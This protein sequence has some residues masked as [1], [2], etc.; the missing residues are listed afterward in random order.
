MTMRM[1]R[2]AACA[3]AALSVLGVWSAWAGAQIDAS[4]Y[5][6]EAQTITL[7]LSG[8][9]ED[10]DLIAVQSMTDLGADPSQW[11]FPVKAADV[12]PGDTQAT[13]ALTGRLAHGGVV[14]FFLVKSSDYIPVEYLR[15][16]GNVW[17]DTG[18]VPDATTTI[19]LKLRQSGNN[20]P[21]FGIESKWFAFCNGYKTTQNIRTYYSFMGK[22]GNVDP[23][24]DGGVHEFSFGADGLVIDGANKTGALTAGA[25]TI[26][27]TLPLFGRRVDGATTPNKF[28][29]DGDI[30]WCRLMK[31]GVTERDYVAA[32]DGDGAFALYDK[33]NHAFCYKKGSG[34]LS[35]GN[36]AYG[37]DAVISTLAV[38]IPARLKGVAYAA[39]TGLVTLQLASVAENLQVYAARAS[40]DR[41]K[42]ADAWQDAEALR[43][44]DVPAGSETVSARLP[45][46]WRTK[47]C[48]VRFFLASALPHVPV[49]YLRTAG[50][51]W[52]DTGV[53]PDVTTTISL[54]LRQAGNNFPLFGIESKWFAFCNG[55]KTTQNIRTYYTFMGKEGD[56]DP[57]NDG[58]VHELSFGA[59]GLVIDGAN[60]TGALTAGTATISST[61]PLFGR[62]VDGATAPSRINDNGDIY[63]CRLVKGGETVRDYVA[64][65]VNGVP[66]FF[67]RRNG[68]YLYNS[69][70]ADLT[71]GPVTLD[72]L[73]VQFVSDAIEI[74]PESRVPVSAAYDPTTRK[75]TLAVPA[76]SQVKALYLAW[77]ANDLGDSV[78]AGW[79]VLRHLVNLAP[80]ETAFEYTLPAELGQQVGACRFFCGPVEIPE[81]LRLHSLHAS[82]VSAKPYTKPY[83]ETGLVPN[84]TSEIAMDCTLDQ[85]GTSVV[86]N[87]PGFGVAGAFYLFCNGPGTYWGFGNVAD[88]L[89][90]KPYAKHLR[91]WDRLS[92]LGAF[93]DNLR[94]V[95]GPFDA[96]TFAASTLTVKFFGRIQDAAGEI[97]GNANM[98]LYSVRYAQD[99][100]TYDYVPAVDADGKPG[101][102][103]RQGGGW[104]FNVGGG[105][106]DADAN[107]VGGEEVTD[108]MV[109]GVSA[110]VNI[111]PALSH[112]LVDRREV[113]V[114]VGAIG[115]DGYL[116]L[117]KGR[118]DCGDLPSAWDEVIFLGEVSAAGGTASYA[119]PATFIRS[120]TVTKVFYS[121]QEQPFG[122]AYS[123]IR[124]TGSQFVDTGI[125]ADTNTEIAVRCKIPE[126]G[127]NNY[128]PFGVSERFYCFDNGPST[129]WGF[130]GAEGN[131]A[132]YNDGGWHTITFGPNGI[133]IDDVE[134]VSASEIV[135]RQTDFGRTIPLFGRMDR[136]TGKMQWL[137]NDM[138]LS[139]ATISQGGAVVRDFMPSVKDGVAGLYDLVT[140]GFFPNDHPDKAAFEL[141]E[142]LG[143]VLIDSETFGAD[144]SVTAPDMGMIFIVR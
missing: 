100:R 62:R 134:K 72:G 144:A 49:A 108:A 129:Y 14:R 95:A 133:F 37:T 79:P 11:A 132:G 56:V 87:L 64:C 67:D 107:L 136:A 143:K 116:F 24:N 58:G 76:G 26:S 57:Y 88:G 32:V 13:V 113:R 74:I 52:M 93:V 5:D 139:H 17:M 35:A 119:L 115:S 30:Y 65:T 106:F 123:F 31:G 90:S 12:A 23:Y 34:D 46:A 127:S 91:H 68:T 97:R 28:N 96:A 102:Y 9:E 75:V 40:E 125:V 59:E 3:V 112:E 82:G 47:A 10:L 140:G 38:R 54:K 2:A 81:G 103:D 42:T 78:E 25:A 4:S 99:G 53:V 118:T 71:A 48:Q 83:L 101:V 55:Y 51:A 110:R 66:A 89:A 21:L 33:Q 15:T 94:P 130:W 85:T 124:S 6:A 61:L 121:R 111:G 141:G 131:F 50:S 22:E 135:T 120:G 109:D 29:T 122:E 60:K 36:L 137:Q 19:S 126:S 142:P 63:W 44:V 92:R 16:A 41:G 114:T 128:P 7:T 27:S 98:T 1:H 70:S 8:V 20:N 104:L 18:V 43:F 84:R 80:E 138:S 69:G 39:E 86:N 45:P 73:E 77:A 117:A 105:A